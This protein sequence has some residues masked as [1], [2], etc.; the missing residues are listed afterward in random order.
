MHSDLYEKIDEKS[1]DSGDFL[2]IVEE[3]YSIQGE[4]FHAGKP[5]YF[6]R[7][8][9][10]D[11]ACHY[12]DTK[13]SWNRSI[14]K[15][16][17]VD[18]IVAKVLETPAR[19]VVVTGGEPTMY[20]LEKLTAKIRENNIESFLE[21][22]GAYPITGQWNW[23][24]ISPK[25]QKKPVLENMTLAN[26]LKVVISSE[27]DFLWAEQWRETVTP[28]CKLFMQPEFSCFDNVI[29]AM[30]EYAKKNPAWNISL[31]IHK[32]MRIP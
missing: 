22:S 14:H 19:S 2:P 13:I 18:D 32:F 6:I 23:V 10:C 16:A 1:I 29:E 12:C 11:I 24:C 17:S 31:Q 25:R 4:G 27:N 9:G 7:V 21:T 28:D 5:A 26:E 3:F 15:L 30:V 8:G 20:N